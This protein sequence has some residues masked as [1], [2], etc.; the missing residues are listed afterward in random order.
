V[1]RPRRDPPNTSTEDWE[2]TPCDDPVAE[3]IRQVAVNLR[4][5]IGGRSLRSVAKETGVPHAVISTLLSGSGWL[6][7]A[8]IARLEIGMNATLWPVQ[9]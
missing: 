5:E 9:D 3:V 1:A 2:N 6:E 7:A 8:T 4:A